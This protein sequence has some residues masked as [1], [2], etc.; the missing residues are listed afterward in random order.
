MVVET[1][2]APM[3]GDERDGPETLQAHRSST[4]GREATGMDDSIDIRVCCESDIEAAARFYDAVVA[5]L[6]STHNYPRWVAGV[7]PSEASVR[8]MVKSSS[9]Y[10]VEEGS[11]ILGAFALNAE[12]QGAYQ[13]GQWSRD[14]EVGTYAVIH[15]LA[16]APEAHRTGLASEVIRF[17][18][19]RASAEGKRAV[20]VDVVP[21]NTPARR[22]F[23]SCR[24]TYVGDVD[25]ELG[26]GDV[27]IFSLYELNI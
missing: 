5:W 24:F 10:L 1:K 18:I 4:K 9:L 14:L 2:G 21:T 20:R 25:L 13:K 3:Q 17:C 11:S 7:Y 15:A 12:P 16:I 26:I 8:S 22:L 27:P 19:D 23:E 6:D